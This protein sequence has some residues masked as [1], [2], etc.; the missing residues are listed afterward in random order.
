[1]RPMGGATPSIK[2]AKCKK[3]FQFP[4]PWFKPDEGAA[5]ARI[6]SERFEYGRNFCNKLWN[7]CRFAFMNLEGYTPGV[8]AESELQVEDRWV[9]SRLA[10]TVREVTTMLE[11]YQFDQATRAVREFTWNEFCDWYLE[12]L[13]PRFRDEAA[14]PVA[15]R[16]LVVVVDTLI[17]LLHP[18]APFI[19]E[20]LWHKLNEV[21]PTRNQPPGVSPRL[22]SA[23]TE[24]VMI[25]AWPDLPLT[26]ID[27]ALEK[28]F[29][30]LQETIVA[31][32]NVR[33]VYGIAPGAPLKLF[34]RCAPDVAEQLK[35]VASQFD[36]LSK[37]MLEAAG[38]DVTAPE[39][40]VS[41]SMPDA[42]GYIPV[43][44]SIDRDAVRKNKE[45][46]AEKLRGFI[47][48]ADK[49]LANE[50]FMAKAP[51]DVVEGIRVTKAEQEA[52]LESI[53]RII[54]ELS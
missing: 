1:M 25:A 21:A 28:R 14:R 54:R 27:A 37:T 7:A 10:T 49:K 20:E 36:F 18:F 48:S 11:R 16:C 40:S 15:Q 35:A 31:V 22:L 24:S 39:G 6:V 5:I 38:L 53:E 47:A 3:S 52:Q 43:G 51:A 50:G 45:K 32:R 4:S 44:D 29:E 19:T 9:L 12:M 42:D 33:S 23:P 41:F 26:L 8:V 30:R 34:M 17:R 13:K 2:C 46:E